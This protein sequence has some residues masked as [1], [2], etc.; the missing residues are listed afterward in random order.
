M[1]KSNQSGPRRLFV[2]QCH[3]LWGT[4]Q[5]AG[6]S[7]AVGGCSLCWNRSGLNI[8]KSHDTV[9]QLRGLGLVLDEAPE[10]S[11]Q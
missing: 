10:L 7:A 4:C 1:L 8:F 5:Q 11:V 3:W 2:P 9:E 6:G